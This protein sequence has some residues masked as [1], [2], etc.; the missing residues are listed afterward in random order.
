MLAR[1]GRITDDTQMTLFTAEGLIRSRVRMALN[2]ICH[3]PTVIDHAYIRWLHTQDEE[4]QRW[5]DFKDDGWLIEREELH[6]IRAPGNTCL[7]ALRGERAGTIE[8]R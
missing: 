2:G 4:S 1:A 5:R 3:E 8:E 7:S 6:A